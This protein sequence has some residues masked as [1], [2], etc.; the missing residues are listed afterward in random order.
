VRA[1]FGAPAGIRTRV[2]GFLPVSVERPKYLVQLSLT[3][4]YL[5]EEEWSP[6]FYRSPNR[7]IMQ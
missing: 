6:F 1:K 3:W 5:A 7:S 2:F 4:L